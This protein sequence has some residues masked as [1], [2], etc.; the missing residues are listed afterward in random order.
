M[1]YSRIS[2]WRETFHFNGS[3]QEANTLVFRIEAHG[4]S[5]LRCHWDIWVWHICCFQNGFPQ[6]WLPGKK[7]QVLT[8]T[9]QLSTLSVHL[10]F[11]KVSG[12]WERND[13]LAAWE[14][15]R[16]SG[17]PD[18]AVASSSSRSGGRR[19]A[20]YRRNCFF[21]RLFHFSHVHRPAVFDQ[22]FLHGSRSVCL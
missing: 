22:R 21:F 18:A 7:A 14:A 20:S 16:E 8:V 17:W 10:S 12:F 5:E 13:L 9:F 4:F 15:G 6:K 3:R 2:L 11:Q 19:G 1:H